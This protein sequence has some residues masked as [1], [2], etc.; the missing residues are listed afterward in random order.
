MDTPETCCGD[1][2]AR[3]PPSFAVMSSLRL[4][5]VALIALAALPSA[6]LRVPPLTTRRGALIAGASLAPGF[7]LPQQM[8]HADSIADIAA[9]SNREAKEAAERKAKAAQG[10][11]L[12]EAAGS[13]LNV[14]LTGASA[15]LLA[16]AGAFALSVKGEVDKTT[17]VNFERERF[18]TDSEKRAALAKDKKRR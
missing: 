15:V 4:A 14:I 11:N 1:R 18:M 17:S 10:V 5:V 2:C 9:K 3:S 7:L 13:G 12:S 8:A 6:A 16:G